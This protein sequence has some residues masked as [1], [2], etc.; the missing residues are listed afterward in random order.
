MI[1]ALWVGPWQTTS[2]HFTTASSGA[3]G[4]QPKAN[5]CVEFVLEKE[6]MARLLPKEDFYKEFMVRGERG[7]I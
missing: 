5:G 6:W 2:G 3:Q 4:G 7:K 1:G